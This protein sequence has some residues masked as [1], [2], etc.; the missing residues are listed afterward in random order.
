ML[1][2]YVDI[3][4]DIWMSVPLH[5][6]NTYWYLLYSV[7]WFTLYKSIW[8]SYVDRS[9]SCKTEPAIYTLHS[10]KLTWNP[11]MKVWTMIFLFKGAM[12]RFHVTLRRSSWSICAPTIFFMPFEQCAVC[13]T[14]PAEPAR[15]LQRIAPVQWRAPW[16]NRKCCIFFK[17][18]CVAV[19]VVVVFE[20]ICTSKIKFLK[21]NWIHLPFVSQWLSTS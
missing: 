2:S 16:K 3:I 20:Q 18:R 9:F 6:F 13:R 19:V 5:V 8:W 4:H 12:F 1:L 15:I 7:M 14:I 21:A 10:R 17:C 11:R